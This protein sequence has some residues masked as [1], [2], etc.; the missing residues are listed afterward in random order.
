MIESIAT[1]LDL[2]I[3]HSCTF[4]SLQKLLCLIFE[5]SAPYIET[6]TLHTKSGTDVHLSFLLPNMHTWCLN[7]VDT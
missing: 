5:S 6:N 2:N 7:K 3:E 4:G 1:D